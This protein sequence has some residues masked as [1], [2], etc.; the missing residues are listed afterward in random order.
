MNSFLLSSVSNY[1]SRS[2]KHL[3]TILPSL[4]YWSERPTLSLA[5][6]Y[7]AEWTFYATAWSAAP[8]PV[9]M[10]GAFPATGLIIAAQ[11]VGISS[12]LGIGTSSSKSGTIE[13]NTLLGT[14]DVILCCIR[15][16]ERINLSTNIIIYRGKAL[17]KNTCE[18]V[19]LFRITCN[20][21]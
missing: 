18:R 8:D 12:L 20:P 2:N 13:P 15:R 6:A 1:V 21:H 14:K 17:L 9:F 4:Q 5:M 11:R 19:L 3:T 7:S 10:P 16:Q